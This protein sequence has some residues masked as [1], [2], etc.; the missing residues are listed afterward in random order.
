VSERRI[1]AFCIGCE[2]DSA[3]VEV[4]RQNGE[5]AAKCERCGFLEIFSEEVFDKKFREQTLDAFL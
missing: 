4:R 3:F 2:K 5:V 1:Y